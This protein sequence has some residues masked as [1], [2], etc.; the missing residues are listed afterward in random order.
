MD[1]EKT[2]VEE[3]SGDKKK[4]SFNRKEDKV[5]PL[6]VQLKDKEAKLHDLLTKEVHLVESKGKE[7][8]GLIS[9]V[10]EI[11]DEM[12]A[13]DKKVEEVEAKMSE[14]Q[15]IK[16]QLVKDKEDRD[17]RLGQLLRKK[18][19]LENFISDTISE[20]KETKIQLEKE[21]GEIKVRLQQIEN[22]DEAP[23]NKIVARPEN[24][25]LFDY[26]NSQI[27]AKEK[28]LECP[29]C[30]EVAAAPIFSCEDQHIICS[31]CRPKVK[32]L[33]S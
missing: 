33:S 6:T 16:N 7:M 14:L 27:E 8:A 12:H 23:L 11:E 30:L 19:K 29:V 28:E 24:L 10:D 13:L 5:N 1:T 31:H 2:H 20:N 15:T 4:N 26:I 9:A 25:E 22:S 3:K 17:K 21:M 18:N 32:H